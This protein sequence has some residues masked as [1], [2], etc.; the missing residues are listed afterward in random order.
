MSSAMTE[1][2]ERGRARGGTFLVQ[3]EIVGPV[4]GAGMVCGSMV[5]A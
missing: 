5:E 4:N 2:G 1:P 3:P